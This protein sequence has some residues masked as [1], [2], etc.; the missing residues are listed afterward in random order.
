MKKKENLPEIVC[1]PFAGVTPFHKKV[2]RKFD[3]QSKGI[4]EYPFTR[5]FHFN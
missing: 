3:K 5:G 1:L 2:E 4:A